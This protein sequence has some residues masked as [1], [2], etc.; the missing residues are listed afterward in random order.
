MNC[1]R[2]LFPSPDNR[3]P[4]GALRLRGRFF[5]QASRSPS[6]GLFFKDKKLQTNPSSSNWSIVSKG[7]NY[8]LFLSVLHCT[9]GRLSPLQHKKNE[10]LIS[11]E[12]LTKKKQKSHA[13]EW[14]K[15]AKNKDFPYYSSLSTIHA[16]LTKL[17]LYCTNP[18]TIML[19][20]NQISMS[21]R[22]FSVSFICF[23]V[24]SG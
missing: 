10:L 6:A 12:N 1:F 7:I 22:S 18:M 17:L 23:S 4:Q 15:G 8:P 9:N 13:K 16:Q 24:F 11:S 5:K 20:I 21:H 2:G 3:F 14:D 19:P